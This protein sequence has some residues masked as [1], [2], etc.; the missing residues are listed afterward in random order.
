M[1]QK[2]LVKAKAV[3]KIV[4]AIKEAGGRDLRAL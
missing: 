4:N 3:E 1:L 2:I